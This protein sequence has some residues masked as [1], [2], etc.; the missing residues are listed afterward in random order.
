MKL[1]ALLAY[2]RC[3]PDKQY[4]PRNNFLTLKY[5]PESLCNVLEEV[6]TPRQ[7]SMESIAPTIAPE[8]MA[9]VD[10]SLSL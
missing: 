7:R 8:Q 3:L 5:A 1:D 4:K 9:E 10:Q 2:A 6:Y